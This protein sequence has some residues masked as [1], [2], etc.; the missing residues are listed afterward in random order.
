MIVTHERKENKKEIWDAQA[1]VY[2][3]GERMD[4]EGTSRGI[5]LIM[6]VCANVL[7]EKEGSSLESIFEAMRECLEQKGDMERA[8]SNR[9]N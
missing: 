4:I 8:E 5:A 9:K 2:D 6:I 7:M 1:R 3:G